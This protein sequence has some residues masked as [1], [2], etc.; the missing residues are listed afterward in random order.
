M[1]SLS[2]FVDSGRQHLNA[3]PLSKRQEKTAI[4]LSLR[5]GVEIGHVVVFILKQI[6]SVKMGLLWAGQ[7]T[8]AEDSR[9]M[10]FI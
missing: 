10:S 6:K 7:M 1:E 2:I 4:R 3:R 5:Y 9:V 8:R